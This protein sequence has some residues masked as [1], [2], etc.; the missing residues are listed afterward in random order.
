MRLRNDCG[1]SISEVD[2]PRTGVV[3]LQLTA[4]VMVLIAGTYVVAGLINLI[5]QA[6]RNRRMP[7]MRV[8]KG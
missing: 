6:W 7:K 2:W 1:C 5:R 8:I 3:L 4:I